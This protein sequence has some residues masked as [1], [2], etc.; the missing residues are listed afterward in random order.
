MLPNYPI[1]EREGKNPNHEMLEGKEQVQ[2]SLG[3]KKMRLW[4]DTESP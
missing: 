4:F 3:T 1:K 2:L